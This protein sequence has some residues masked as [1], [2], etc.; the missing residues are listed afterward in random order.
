MMVVSILRRTV[1][2]G[3]YVMLTLGG[4]AES[5]GVQA[6]PSDFTQL[7][8]EAL[9]AVVNI[10]TS[11][12]L[13]PPEVEVPE[14][15]PGLE[16]FFGED[17][18]ERFFGRRVPRPRMSSLGSGFIIDPAGYVV[19]NNHVV[20]RAGEI[21][22]V[23][24][25]K[26]E[27]EANVVGRDSR[28]DLALLKVESDDP[29]PALEWG[30][31]E[32]LEIGEWVVA[33]GNPFGLGGTVTAGIISQRGREIGAGPY[34]D[35]IQTDAAIN[36]GN[37]G[38]PLLNTEGKVVGVNSAILSPTGANIGIGFAIPS[39]LAKP[40]VDQL[41]VRGSVSRGWLG[42]RIQPVTE[43]LA[44]ALGLPDT[45]GALVASVEDGSPA[46]SGGIEAGDVVLEFGGDPVEDPRDLSRAVAA[47]PPGKQ[48]EIR[49]WRDNRERTIVIRV[50][51][52]PRET[53]ARAIAPGQL[54][55]AGL[56]LAELSPDV[57]E[58]HSIPDDLTGVLVTDVEQG[59]AAAA[60]GFR[61]RDVITRI[62][63]REV[64]QLDDVVEAM[65]AARGEHVRSVTVLVERDGGSLFLTLPVEPGR[66]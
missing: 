60:R 58:R 18:F 47:V 56:S 66:G 43:E 3:A 1:V 2:A 31:S 26:T 35:F 17:F 21:T 63:D 20:A 65:K 11:D 9:P 37:S 59:S 34:D 23:L 33:I 46:E 38:G 36:R 45:K 25:D 15:P 62:A 50:G 57:R 41:R 16:E 55:M 32:A 44:E 53:L 19:T 54:E 22:V 51:E 12:T 64:N 8:R 49:L 61:R 52:M 14:L 13:R 29:L 4:A 28:T 42:I 30:D 6:Q 40:V 27:F 7:A 24:Q 10:S 5:A 39:S 48:I